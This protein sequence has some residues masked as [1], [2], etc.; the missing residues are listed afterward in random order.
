MNVET[1]RRI[2]GVIGLSFRLRVMIEYIFEDLVILNLSL[3]SL[4]YVKISEPV[5]E[6][7]VVKSSRADFWYSFLQRSEA[8]ETTVEG[9]S[10][11]YIWFPFH[12]VE[13]TE[14]AVERVT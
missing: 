6:Y 4:G 1:Y 7:V 10:G 2:G 8:T 14:I 9:V 11:K 5:G 13:V 12:G 3:G